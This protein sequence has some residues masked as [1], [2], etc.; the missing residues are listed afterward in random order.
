MTEQ[1]SVKAKSAWKSFFNFFKANSYVGSLILII[2]LGLIFVNNFLSPT[3][4]STLMLQATIK[5]ILAIGMTLVITCNMFDLSVGSQLGFI[6]ATGIL[7]YNATGSFVVMIV[8]CIVSGA[9]L[10]GVNGILVTFGKMPT[11]IATLST[12]IIYRSIISQI[13][14][15]NAISFKQSLM[16]PINALVNARILK[17]INP[18][19]II[20]IVITILGCLLLYKTRLGRN[21]TACG[22]NAKAARLAGISVYKTKILSFVLSGICVGISALLFASRLTSV[23]CAT[24]GEG[25]ESDAI[26]ALAIGGTKIGGGRGVM[27]GTFVG[28]IILI[29]IEQIVVAAKV[30]AYLADAVKGLVIIVAILAQTLTTKSEAV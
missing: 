12:Q 10:S 3:N 20:F 9:I 13:G 30:S 25:Y 22:S 23:T 8:F 14:A 26:A 28:A 24:A 29:T 21:I 6:A 16:E 19:M 7:V 1:N 17:V 5:G 15:R 11:F 27:I 2:I 4:I 18:F